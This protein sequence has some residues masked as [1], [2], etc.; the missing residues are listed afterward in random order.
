MSNSHCCWCSP[1]S[2]K[3]AWP[4]WIIAW[5][6]YVELEWISEL[7]QNPTLPPPGN[8]LF[9]VHSCGNVSRGPHTGYVFSTARNLS[10]SHVPSCTRKVYSS[11]LM[12][13]VIS[14]ELTR[15][16]LW[17]D[18]QIRV[19]PEW[20]TAEWA[21]QKRR[22]DVKGERDAEQWEEMMNLSSHPLTTE[23]LLRTRHKTCSGHC[24]CLPSI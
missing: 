4:F 16:S 14:S 23:H 7:G 22:T 21:G 24:C 15:R 10:T 1:G 9:P 2:Q 3:D 6:Q 5:D 8:T 17:A 20:G 11:S 13:R 12:D 19:G 18:C